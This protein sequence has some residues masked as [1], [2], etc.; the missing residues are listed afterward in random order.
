MSPRPGEQEEEGRTVTYTFY[1]LS[2]PD[3]F[4]AD[5]PEPEDVYPH[6]LNQN[7]ADEVSLG[8]ILME[9]DEI[10]ILKIQFSSFWFLL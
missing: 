2:C 1:N 8:G 6:L 3:H 7:L 9:S 4:S 10:T 5:F